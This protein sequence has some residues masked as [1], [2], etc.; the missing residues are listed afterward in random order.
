MRQQGQGL[1]RVRERQQ[2]PEQ[3]EQAQLRVCGVLAV[4]L[5]SGLALRL[6]LPQRL[7]ERLDMARAAAAVLR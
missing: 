2:V 3:P 5:D 1:L 4:A 7:P 6:S